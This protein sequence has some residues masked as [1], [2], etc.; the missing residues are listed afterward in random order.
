M[1]WWIWILIGFGLLAIE[2]VSTTLHLGLFA[3]GAFVVAVLVAL[4]V[5]LPL[6]G[7]LVVFTGVSLVSLLVLRPILVRKL[8]LDKPSRVDTMVGE[9]AV[10]LED[11]A[12]AGLGRAE[13][14]GT[15]WSARNIGSSA[16]ARGQRCIVE[17]VDGLVLHV[18]AS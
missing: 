17:H 4:G 9:A 2:F 16:L 11:I 8:R 3:V 15:T 6:W 12:E 14:R 10:A 5:P 13:M 7:Q 18:R 1:T